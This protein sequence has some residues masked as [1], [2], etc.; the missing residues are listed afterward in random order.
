MEFQNNINADI[1]YKIDRIYIHVP[2]CIKKCDYCSFHS[3][4]LPADDTI[5]K[6]LKKI[7]EDIIKNKYFINNYIRSIYIGGGTPS[8]LKNKYIEKIFYIL[9][10]HFSLDKNTEITMECNPHDIVSEKIKIISQFI[11]RISIGIQTFNKKLNSIIGR[12]TLIEH[13]TFLKIFNLI[14]KYGINNTSCD[15]IFGIP[16]QTKSDLIEDLNLITQIPFKHISAYN[17]SFEK[18]TKLYKKYHKDIHKFNDEYHFMDQEIKKKLQEKHYKK[19]EISNYCLNNYECNHNHAIWYGEKYIGFGPTAASFDGNI[20]K[21]ECT[22]DKW[23][24]KTN[25]CIYDKISQSKRI[26][27][28]LIIGLRAKNGW[29]INENNNDTLIYSKF[30]DYFIIKNKQW[31]KIREKILELNKN[32]LIT[33]GIDK[34][35]KINKI[36]LTE[37]GF[38]L[39]N[40]IGEILIT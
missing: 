22:L 4:S 6:Y 33:I 5:N 17:L 38:M 13:K 19:Y 18:Q 35:N 11:N 16:G 26:K 29:N 3:V 7:E 27:E 1:N 10:E 30:R 2:F 37:K 9:N 24:M 21:I 40:S 31:I 25:N 15:I 23:I 28:I 8:Y 12:S 20:R 32:K 39:W 14:E 36:K 34:N